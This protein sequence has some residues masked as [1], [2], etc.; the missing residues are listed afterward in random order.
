MDETSSE[1]AAN[2][3]NKHLAR[4]LNTIHTLRGARFRR[5]RLFR[6]CTNNGRLQTCP[7]KRPQY[8]SKLYSVGYLELNQGDSGLLQIRHDHDSVMPLIAESQHSFI[9]ENVTEF[10]EI[11]C[12][13]G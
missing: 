7:T 2:H 9:D 10:H 13:D 12:N 6:T 3:A 5:A 4:R 1:H 11:D 8:V